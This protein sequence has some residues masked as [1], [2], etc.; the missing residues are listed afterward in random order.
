MLPDDDDDDDDDT[1]DTAGVNDG[2]DG[3]ERADDAAVT[4]SEDGAVVAEIRNDDDSNNDDGAGD[5]I[6]I[7]TMI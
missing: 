1:D 4:I 6:M 2:M 5:K 3:V 7:L